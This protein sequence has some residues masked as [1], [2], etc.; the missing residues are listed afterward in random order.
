MITSKIH[1]IH[2][3]E[4]DQS[5]STEGI[6]LLFCSFNCTAWDAQ[7]TVFASVLL[8]WWCLDRCFAIIEPLK[9]LQ[10]SLV[11]RQFTQLSL[12]SFAVFR[13]LSLQFYNH[14]VPQKLSWRRMPRWLKISE[15]IS[16]NRIWKWICRWL[17]TP[18]FCEFAHKDLLGKMEVVLGWPL[19]RKALTTWRSSCLFLSPLPAIS[20]LMRCWDASFIDSERSASSVL[21][22][23]M[24]ISCDII[25]PTSN[26]T[27]CSWKL[28]Y[29][30]IEKENCG[31]VLGSI[32]ACL[33]RTIYTEWVLASHARSKL[34]DEG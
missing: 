14:Y 32:H 2:A 16:K 15:E 25:K 8:L 12:T 28:C 33:I 21:L 34:E 10:L 29:K 23:I 3:R 27:S 26:S 31:F 4:K 1:V 20:Y 5:W 7:S 13:S 17:Y 6:S 9:C 19:C 11:Y 24:S 18:G 22:I 30:A